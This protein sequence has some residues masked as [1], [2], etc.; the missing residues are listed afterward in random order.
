VRRSLRHLDAAGRTLTQ[1]GKLIPLARPR[2]ALTALHI[3][4]G[5]DEREWLW[6]LAPVTGLLMLAS[7]L[8]VVHAVWCHESFGTEPTL[9][10][11]LSVLLPW[12]MCKGWRK[13]G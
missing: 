1:M 12:L 5:A 4:L 13:S 11:A 8:R 6:H 3:D 7:V 9:A 2:R 10:L